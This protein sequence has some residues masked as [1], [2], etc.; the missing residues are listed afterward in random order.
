MVHHFGAGIDTA[1][2]CA[3]LQFGLDLPFAGGKLQA[4]SVRIALD[5]KSLG[6]FGMPLP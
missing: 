3:G 4:L 5:L 1:C 6:T 2:R